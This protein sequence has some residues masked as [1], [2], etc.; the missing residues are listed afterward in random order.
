MEE[1]FRKLK[2][3]TNIYVN[4]GRIS[5]TTSIVCVVTQKSRFGLSQYP[6][7]CEIEC[8]SLHLKLNIEQF[9]TYD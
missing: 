3:Q 5:N 6:F 1:E 2:T 8:C 9:V 7:Y 4:Y